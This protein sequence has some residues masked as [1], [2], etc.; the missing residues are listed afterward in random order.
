MLGR[1][2]CARFVLSG[3]PA[4]RHSEVPV[5]EE[6]VQMMSRYV[7]V[8]IENERGLSSRYRL[9]HLSRTEM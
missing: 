1:P 3:S 8:D 6:T 7:R 5:F 9:R 4:A 2:S